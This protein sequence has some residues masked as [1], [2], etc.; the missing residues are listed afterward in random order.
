M[1]NGPRM[2]LTSASEHVPEIERRIRVVKERAR[3]VRHSLPFNRIPKILL[4]HIVLHAG[5]MLTYFPTKAGISNTLSPRAIL[6]GESLDYSKHLS[7]Q[8]GQYCQVH[9]EDTPR[10]GQAARTK[11]A[12]CMGTCGNQQGGYKFLSLRS[13]KKITRRAWDV[14]PMPD[15]VIARVNALGHDQPKIL[16]FTDRKGRQIGEVEPTGVADAV[17]DDVTPTHELQDEVD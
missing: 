3:A 6:T 7:L 13:G 14:I 1:K 2:N 10:N 17:D 16:M 8:L 9:E 11:G 5:K 12:I 4:I 15:L